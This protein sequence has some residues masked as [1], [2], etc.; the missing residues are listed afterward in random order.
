MGS[1][2]VQ[3]SINRLPFVY[4]YSGDGLI[5]GERRKLVLFYMAMILIVCFVIY[6]GLE[7]AVRGLGF[8]DL[9]LIRGEEIEL[10]SADSIENY[11]NRKA[12]SYGWD[13]DLI[14]GL[15]TDLNASV[16]DTICTILFSGDSVTRGTEVDV[17]KEAYPMLL[18]KALNRKINLRVLNIAIRGLG[19]DQMMLK[20][21]ELVPKY[22]PD[23]IVF[24]YIPTDLWRPARNINYGST[25]PVLIPDS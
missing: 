22:R 3:N 6:A 23:L 1:H 7:I 18:L 19:L 17:T 16:D 4:L 14:S 13:E 20:L 9:A 5:M 11:F 12:P 2:R 15:P 21:E 8:P 25:K 10:A 24:A